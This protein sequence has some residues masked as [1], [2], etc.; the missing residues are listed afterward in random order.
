MPLKLDTGKES[1]E[2]FFKDWQVEA[3]RYLWTVQPQGANSRAV[4]N[5]VNHR[6]QGSISRASIIN[7]LNAKV[8]E[9]LITYT[10]TTGK[11][12]S[13]KSIN[14]EA[15]RGRVQTTHRRSHYRSCLKNTSKK[16]WK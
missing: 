3:L 4:W 13:P 6:F 10:E 5:N 8:E 12:G 15:R 9:D 14:H 2:M 7:H 11:G 1:L 16:Q